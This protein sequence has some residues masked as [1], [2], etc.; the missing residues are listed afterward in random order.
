MS[1]CPQV[2][3]RRV[4]TEA[5]VV[6][7]TSFVG[8]VTATTG[9]NNIQ[10]TAKDAAGNSTT[11]TWQVVATSGTNQTLTYDPD[12]NLLNDGTQTYEWDVKIVEKSN[13][14]VTSTKNLL[15]CGTEIC[16]ERDASNSV[17]RRYYPQGMQ[18]SG[19]NYFYTRDHLGSVR[20]LTDS[21]GVIQARYSYDPYGRR[22][23][24][25]GSMAADFG[26]TGDYWHAPSGLALTLYRGYNADLRRWI[27]R[28][29]LG[30][31]GGIN[32][33]GY[34][35]N[36]PANLIDPLGLDAHF[37]FTDG[38]TQ[39]ASNASE[40]TNV[41][42][43][44]GNN[45]IANI[46]VDGHSSPD[47]AGG[48]DTQDLGTSASQGSILLNA[49]GQ[50]YLFDPLSNKADPT[51]S[52]LL[53]NKLS[54]NATITL[55]GCN[56]GLPTDPDN[57]AKAVSKALPTVPV[58]GQNQNLRHLPFTDVTVPI[59]FYSTTTTYINGVAQ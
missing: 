25:S 46:T 28:D 35:M 42:S 1:W 54:T 44:A 19:S 51:L 47:A 3:Q 18:I 39:S 7:G 16:E 59:P 22:I 14:A 56:S 20:E 26:F 4:R 43:A 58:T 12:G 13:G 48:G 5:A 15:W 49:N 21:S 33:Y 40:F 17:T 6:T 23:K 27:S 53:H 8:T 52:D 36:D 55:H 41:V 10:I 34:V 29:P 32:L 11:H 38:S 30:E 24:L 50:P 9:T 2:S 37:T 57:I 45:T 31:R